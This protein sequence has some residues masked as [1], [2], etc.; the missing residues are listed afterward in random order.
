M[1]SQLPL[2]EVIETAK[3]KLG[4]VSSCLNDSAAF[5][6]AVSEF[7]N[8]LSEHKEL[9]AQTTTEQPHCRQE[10]EQLIR[11]LTRL[12]M[13]ARYNMSLVADMQGYIHSQLE[14]TPVPPHPYHR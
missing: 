14:T 5:A 8:W 9:I 7:D 2:S 4:S 11:K 3:Q 13:Q 10:I 6:T 12:E 1:I